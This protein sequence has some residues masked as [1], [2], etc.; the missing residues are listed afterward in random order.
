LGS[1][2][3]CVCGVAIGLTKK[4]LQERLLRYA[5]TE[6]Q[7]LKG[8]FGVEMKND[9]QPIAVSVFVFQMTFPVFRLSLRVG[10]G[11]FISW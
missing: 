1:L 11:H 3:A 7:A 4:P 5:V 9:I 10:L 6:C 2:D 8:T